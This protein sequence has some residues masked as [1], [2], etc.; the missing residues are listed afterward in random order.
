MLAVQNVDVEKSC[1]AVVVAVFA[2]MP[3]S[4]NVPPLRLRADYTKGASEILSVGPDFW[5]VPALL[6][7]TAQHGGKCLDSATGWRGGK[8]T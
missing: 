4:G 8:R 1:L 2:L 6:D 5:T 3:S 7:I